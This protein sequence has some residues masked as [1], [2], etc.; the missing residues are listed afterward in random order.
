MRLKTVLFGAALAAT[1]YPAAA[2]AHVT[3]NPSEAATGYGYTEFRVPHGCDGAATT[4][5][6]VQ[7]P[8]GI[9]SVKPEAVA[10]WKVSTKEGTLPEPVDV[11]GESVTE[12]V[13]EI[14]WTGGPLPDSQLQNFGVSFFASESL[15]GETAW[16]RV[17]QQCSEGVHRWVEIPIEG[18]EEP[19]EPAP[20]IAILASD[21]GEE[22]DAAAAEE[23]P[24][25]T[26]GE[27]SAAAVKADDAADRANLGLI[28]GIAG[29]IAGLIALGLALF[30]PNLG[31]K[32][33]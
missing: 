14:S 26:V 8:A 27:V 19:E 30:R 7:I 9:T 16:F 17:V 3:A 2:A 12:G 21:G 29:L 25:P 1:V 10:G 13:T 11:F 22:E 18:E 24:G 23:E 15:A 32:Q 6:T 28:F 4:S 5:V 20:G 31:R 33:T